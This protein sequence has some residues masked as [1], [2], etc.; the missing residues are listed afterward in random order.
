MVTMFI[1]AILGCMAGLVL[2]ELVAEVDGSHQLHDRY[3]E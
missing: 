1:I 2:Y 3:H